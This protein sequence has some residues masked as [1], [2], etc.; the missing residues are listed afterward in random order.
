MINLISLLYNGL[1]DKIMLTILYNKITQTLWTF[2][3]LLYIKYD[4]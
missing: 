2:N 1:C 4:I 3:I